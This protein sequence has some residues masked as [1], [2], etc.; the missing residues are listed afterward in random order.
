MEEKEEGSA[1]GHETKGQMLRRHKLELVKW[2]KQ[3]NRLNKKEAAAK[4]A[5][6][7]SRHLVE[8]ERWE[9]ENAGEGEVAGEGQEGGES[10]QEESNEAPVEEPKQEEKEEVK[11]DPGEAQKAAKEKQ[12][13]K[14]KEKKM[15]TRM[16]KQVQQPTQQNQG[17]DK[18][19]LERTALNQKLSPFG[20]EVK[21]IR[22][23]GNC[24]FSAVVDQLV[25]LD[26]VSQYND[27]TLRTATAQYLLANEEDFMPFMDTDHAGYV[28]YCNDMKTPGKWGGHH[29]IVALAKLLQVPIDVI[30]AYTPNMT[31][32]EEFPKSR[33][34]RITFHR[35][36]YTLG[37]HYNSVGP[38][39]EK[40]V[41][42]FYNIN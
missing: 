28:K 41:D 22:A 37:E 42:D 25:L 18:K 5:E 11:P 8:I 38:I 13:N 9:A 3:A 36:E 17:P 31:I 39:Q 21:Q 14:K 40:P 19:Q 24:L 33:T 2:K 1:Q 16:K 10:G 12:R 32:G 26:G 23:D 6:L 7:K 27:K 29:E 30:H 34:L 15:A 4:E 35:S 20:L